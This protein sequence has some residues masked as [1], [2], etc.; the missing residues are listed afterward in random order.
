VDATTEQHLV[1][2]EVEI[3]ARPDDLMG[4]DLELAERIRD[5][6]AGEPGPD[7]RTM[8]GGSRS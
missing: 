7:E 2:R 3:D 5:L 8:F 4:Y 1:E 6:L